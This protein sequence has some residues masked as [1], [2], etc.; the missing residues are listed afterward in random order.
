[1]EHRIRLASNW[2]KDRIA[3]YMMGAQI[4]V[5][6]RIVGSS[7]DKTDII[8]SLVEDPKAKDHSFILY[9]VRADT[10]FYQDLK[11][12]NSLSIEGTMYNLRI[13]PSKHGHM[14]SQ[15]WHVSIDKTVTFR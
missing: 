2:F 15:D 8:L 9:F 13:L 6:T 7:F 12:V 1:M 3:C 11:L 14:L 4:P 10:T 5:G